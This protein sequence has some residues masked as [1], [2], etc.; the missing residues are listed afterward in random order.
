MVKTVENLM[1]IDIDY[2]IEFNFAS[3]VQVVDAVGGVVVD[4]PVSFDAQC[5]NI[6]TDELAVFRLEAGE[7]VY[8]D[9]ARALGFVRERMAFPDGRRAGLS[10]SF[11]HVAICQ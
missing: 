1:G 10:L 4:I 9:G 5:W 2:T 11:Y 7:N 8:L 6:Y 3:V